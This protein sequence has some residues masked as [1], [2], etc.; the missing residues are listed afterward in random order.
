MHKASFNQNWFFV[1]L[2]LIPNF[3]LVNCFFRFILL[4][5]DGVSRAPE[6]KNNLFLSGAGGMT[7]IQGIGAT[8]SLNYT[9]K[10]KMINKLPMREFACRRTADGGVYARGCR[11]CL[12]IIFSV[13]TQRSVGSTVIAIQ[14][15]GGHK[16]K[17]NHFKQYRATWE[18]N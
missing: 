6:V 4:W 2:F 10:N 14:G 9:R 11:P 16:Q 8:S 13:I 18:R 7:G 3:S 5:L 17:H 15:D 1:C 12:V